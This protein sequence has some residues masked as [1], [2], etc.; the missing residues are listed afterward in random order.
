MMPRTLLVLAV[1]GLA[2]CG[3]SEDE[4]RAIAREEV[5]RATTEHFTTGTVIGPYSPAVQAGRLL[6]VSGQIGID[7]ATGQFRNESIEE[8]TRQVLANVG[9]VLRQAGYD[10]SHV[11]NATV[12]LTDMGDYGRMNAVYGGFFPEGRYPAR[13]TVE[14]DDLPRDARVEIAVVAY[15]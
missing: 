5:A 15:K 13:A 3:P 6:F 11:V 9:A 7:P 4:V 8:E 1:L 14:V 2:G 12:Y 10:S